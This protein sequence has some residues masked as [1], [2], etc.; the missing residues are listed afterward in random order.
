MASLGKF[1]GL[2]SS[3][4]DGRFDLLQ[5]TVQRTS[6]VTLGGRGSAV[7]IINTTRLQRIPMGMTMQVRFIH[8]FIHFDRI[9]FVFVSFE[10]T[11]PSH[12]PFSLPPHL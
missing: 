5:L 3:A 6:A 9:R 7:A 4:A 11:S 2:L 8:P 12:F 1:E 10:L